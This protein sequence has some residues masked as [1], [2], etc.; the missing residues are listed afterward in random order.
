MSTDS[1][2]DSREVDFYT[3]LAETWWDRD[4]PF[5]PLHKLNELR[6]AYI[7]T[8]RALAEAIDASPVRLAGTLTH[9]HSADREGDSAR[10]QWTRFLYGV[11]WLEQAGRAGAAPGG[12]NDRRRDR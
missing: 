4:G 6:V 3:S 9:F 1:T 7:Q 11:D 10:E 8:I 5:W 12:Q 2:V